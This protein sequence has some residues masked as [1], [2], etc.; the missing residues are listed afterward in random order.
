MRLIRVFPGLLLLI[1]L[2]ISACHTGL[3]IVNP[4]TRSDP[5]WRVIQRPSAAAP[6]YMLVPLAAPPTVAP[7][8]RPPPGGLSG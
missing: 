1:A 2:G 3:R 4:A 8:S 5:S 6:A 7:P